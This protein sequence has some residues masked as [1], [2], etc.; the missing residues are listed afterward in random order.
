VNR[1]G[2]I[3]RLVQTAALDIDGVRMS[4]ALMPKAGTASRAKSAFK[5]VT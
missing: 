5:L 1:S 3:E 2:K 4:A